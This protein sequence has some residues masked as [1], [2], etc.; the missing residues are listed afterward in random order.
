M[1]IERVLVILLL[2]TRGRS[3]KAFLFIVWGAFWFRHHP[4]AGK[5][6]NMATHVR[7]AAHDIETRKRTDDVLLSEGI[8]FSSLLLSQAV[9]DGLSSAGFHKPSPIQLKAIPLGRCGL[10]ESAFIRDVCMEIGL[11]VLCRAKEWWQKSVCGL[12][13]ALNN[14]CFICENVEIAYSNNSN[15]W[16]K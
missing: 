2:V 1:Q 12:L 9:L 7:R 13:C 4:P 3:N 10:G 6:S 14:C 15:M 8:E 11:H 16:R 5:Q